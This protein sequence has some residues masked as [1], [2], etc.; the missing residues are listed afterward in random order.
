MARILRWYMI[1]EVAM[2]TLLALF[3]ITFI[4]LI[5]VIFD[6]INLVLQPGISA[7][8]VGG[9][10]LSSLPSILTF[11]APMAILIGCLIGV[12]RLTLDREILAIRANAEGFTA[13][14][15]GLIMA[16]NYAGFLVGCLHAP[17][18][19]ERVGHIRTY[20]ALTAIASAAS[21]AHALVLDAAL[22]AAFRGIANGSSPRSTRRRFSD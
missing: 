20:A 21:L 5:R 15:V 19:I 10:L 16:A 8:Q 7:W 14:T 9:V 3:T 18:L 22:W 6:M 1:R 12:G 11:A 17:K 2:P 4:L 13:G